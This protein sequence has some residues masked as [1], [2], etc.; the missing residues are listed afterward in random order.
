MTTGVGSAPTD[1]W[2]SN[3]STGAVYAFTLDEETWSQQAYIKASNSG[4]EDSFGS[5]LALSG[6]GATLAVG[7]Q[8]EDSNSTGINGNEENDDAQQAGVVYLFARSDDSWLQRAYIKGSNTEA[9][10]EFGGAIALSGDGETLVVDTPAKMPV[11][12]DINEIL[13][14]IVAAEILTPKEYIGSI[15]TLCQKKRGVYRTT[16]YL[17]PE[18]ALVHYDLPLGEIIFDFYDKLKSISSGYASFDY[19]FKE[20]EKASLQKMDILIPVSY[21]H[22][23][24]H[25]TLR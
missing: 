15:M 7:A 25:E 1:D 18:K 2:E 16:H 3:T 4:H 17:S 19:E 21:T 6:D 14:P 13:E 24:A 8:L 5:R 12:G 10:D 20:F 9:F 23:R 11:T 22:L